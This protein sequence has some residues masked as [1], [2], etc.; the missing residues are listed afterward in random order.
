LELLCELAEA[1]AMSLVSS[2]VH[3][4]DRHVRKCAVSMAMRLKAKRSVSA[5]I[6]ALRDPDEDVQRLAAEALAAITGIAIERAPDGARDLRTLEL[7]VRRWWT[8]H[9]T[10]ELAQNYALPHGQGAPR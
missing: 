2:M 9:R 8:V 5:L 10:E 4:R 3:D 7:A 6:A 1:S